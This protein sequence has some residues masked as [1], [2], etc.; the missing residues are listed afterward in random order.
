[1][2]PP[3]PLD[4]MS[5]VAMGFPL[6]LLLALQLFHPFLFLHGLLCGVPFLGLTALAQ[7][8]STICQT[9]KIN[10]LRPTCRKIL[11]RFPFLLWR[12][13]FL[14]LISALMCFP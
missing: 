4:P 12:G 10:A 8:G 11:R 6:D 2:K 9:I 13:A 3:S 5:S 1:L 14:N 7:R